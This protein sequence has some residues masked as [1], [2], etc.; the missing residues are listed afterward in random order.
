MTN[1]S[2]EEIPERDTNLLSAV[3][4]DMIENAE[5]SDGPI[6]DKENSRSARFGEQI[7][8]NAGNHKMALAMAYGAETTRCDQYKRMDAIIKNQLYSRDMA[9]YTTS[10]L[11][12]RKTI[13]SFNSPALAYPQV[14]STTQR[15]AVQMTPEYREY[16]EEWRVYNENQAF[17]KLATFAFGQTDPSAEFLHNLFH[18]RKEVVK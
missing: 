11:E 18:I 1:N 6:V 14:T 8:L 7:K 3:I 2:Q 17:H 16:M 12:P 13:P 9:G 4:L 5:E 10:L 15:V